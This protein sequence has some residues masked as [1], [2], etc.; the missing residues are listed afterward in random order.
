M[1]SW[2][3]A[4]SSRTRSSSW[5]RIGVHVAVD[6]RRRCLGQ[7]GRGRQGPQLG[8]LGDP[9]QEGQRLGRLAPVDEEPGQ[10]G[11][12]ARVVGL[13]LEGPAQ[14]GLVAGRRQLVGLAGRRGQALDELGHLGLGQRPDEAVDDLSRRR[15]AKTAGIDCTLKLAATWRV[16]VHVDL[17]Q[18]DG[19]AGGRTTRSRMG[20]RVLHGPHHGAHR[21]TT[22]GTVA[23]RA[24]TSCSNVASVTSAIG[25]DPTG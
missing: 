11:Q 1:N 17:G 18:L 10:G 9:G 22:T 2:R 20:P 15:T 8:G 3:A 6:R 21:S 5:S 19:A 16:L 24:I 25:P 13:E 12:G 4:S 7:A 14:R 23:D